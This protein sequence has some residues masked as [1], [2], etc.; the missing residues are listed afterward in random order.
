MR[1]GPICDAKKAMKIA[2]I[3]YAKTNIIESTVCFSA[4]M[5]VYGFPQIH[6]SSWPMIHSLQ[7]HN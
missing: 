2:K 3:P 4:G 6:R 5:F 7:L 1:I